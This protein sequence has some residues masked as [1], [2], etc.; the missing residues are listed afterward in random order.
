[1]ALLSVV[2]ALPLRASATA[3]AGLHRGM[4]T[5]VGLMSCGLGLWV[6]YRIGVAERLLG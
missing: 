6:V 5:A 3:L 2:I 1:M 4:S